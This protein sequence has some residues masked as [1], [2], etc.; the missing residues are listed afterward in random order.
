[1]RD[2]VCVIDGCH[3]A[4]TARGLCGKH[5]QQ[6]SKAGRL[7]E[8][9]PLPRPSLTIEERFTRIGWTVTTAGCW[10]WNGGRNDRGYGKISRGR[11]SAGGPMIATRVAWEIH[12]GPIPDGQYV[13][14][15]CDNPP[16]VNPEHLFLGTR[17]VNNADMASKKRTA[18]GERR[19]QAKLTDDQ[20]DEIR[21]RYASEGI[22]QKA[23]GREYGV[24]QSTVSLIVNR[25]RRQS[26][27]YPVAG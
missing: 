10:E 17:A 21:S 13:C 23:L 1:M 3:S 11:V 19:P 4:I 12:N 22:S 5:Y 9:K 2:R 6:M 18:N 24:D 20:V 25:S 8:F 27:T 14:H 26:R 16:C 15:R 7:A